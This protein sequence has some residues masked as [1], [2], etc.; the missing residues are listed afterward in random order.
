MLLLVSS[1]YCL[2]NNDT[3][4]VYGTTNNAAQFGLNWVM[5]NVL[6][7]QAGLQVSN[8]IYQY[9]T[10]KNTDDE[11]IVHVQN[12]NA[13]GT[14]YI[15]RSSDDWTGLPGNTINKAVPVDYI[16]ISYWGA[17][18]IEVEGQGSVTGAEVYYTYQ[19][20][21]CF[22]PQSNPNCPGYEDPFVVELNEVDVYD[23]LEDDLVQEEL[24][25]KANRKAQEDEEKERQRK[26]ALEKVEEIEKRLEDLLGIANDT[27]IAGDAQRLH[28]L[29]MSLRGI[30][31][32]YQ[33]Q[34]IGGVLPDGAMPPDSKIPS[35]S[36]G[37][38]QGLASEL[39]HQ[40]LVN[41][42]YAK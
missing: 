19:Y 15:F 25:R 18:S 27:D 33:T 38:R 8:V 3:A 9:T 21:P 13:R 42:Q 39:R 35:N 26:K 40:E 36:R 31:Q 11:M 7:Q 28:E 20:D 22:D 5:R 30:P 24:D 1:S 16:D 17:G 10:V 23:P 29:L 12:E 6:P 2:S 32:S 37:L 41:L 34:L 14:G 4:P